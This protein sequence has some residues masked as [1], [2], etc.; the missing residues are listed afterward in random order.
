MPDLNLSWIVLHPD[1]YLAERE[2]LQI[3]YPHLKLDERKLD[4]GRLVYWGEIMVRPPGGTRRH[5][6]CLAYP[7]GF[8]FELP[9]IT[10][11]EAIPPFDEHGAT[12][13]GKPKFF[14]RRHQMPEGNLCLFQRETRLREAIGEVTG[15]AA[16]RRAEH[17]FLG[18]Y[19]GH[20]PPDSAESELEPHFRYAGDVL[21]SRCFYQDTITGRGRLWMVPDLSRRHDRIGEDGFPLIVTSLSTISS[22]GVENVI[23]A[24]DDISKVYPWIAANAFSPLSAAVTAGESA[25][26]EEGYW[27]A[28]NGEPDPFRDG[29]GFLKALSGVTQDGDGWD[30]VLH[31][32]K[33]DLSLKTR[34]YLA[35]RY[36]GRDGEP[37]WLV[38]VM[39]RSRMTDM[40]ANFV[41]SIGTASGSPTSVVDVS[42]TDDQKRKEFEQ[43]PVFCIR[44]HGLRPRDLRLRNTGVTSLELENKTVAFIGL[45]ALGAT[46]AELL[47]KAGIGSLRLCDSDRLVPGNVVRHVGSVQDFGASKVR[48]V[49]S[50][51]FSINPYVEI[52]MLRH[53]SATTSMSDLTDFLAASDLTIV[54][55][56]DEAVES[57]INQIAVLNRNVVLYGRALRRADVGR[58]FLVRPRMDACK[59][60]LGLYHRDSLAGAAT[61][62]D[63]ISVD[64]RPSDVLL[65]ECG[66]PVIPASAVDLAFIAALIARV[67]LDF[68]QG[69]ASAHNHFV[70]TRP[71][72]ADIDS[73]LAQPL[74]T[75]SA[76]L[77]PNPECPTCEEPEVRH[78]R[79]SKD[80]HDTITHFAEKTPNAE[81]GGILIGYV[82]SDGTA[83]VLQVTEPGPKSTRSARLFVRD[84]DFTQA[85]LD[86]A[87]VQFGEKG[88]YLG[89]WHSHLEIEPRP[90][91][92]DLDSMVGIARAQNYLTRCPIMI[93]VGVDSS[94]ARAEVLKAWSVPLGGTVYPIGT[95]VEF[96]G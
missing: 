96:V 77:P 94:A 70:W 82:D 21:L 23:D 86:E 19:T 65:H 91:S 54:T 14:D 11:L 32:L 26:L 24:R 58:V 66:R 27:W 92:L 36:P 68:L 35:L 42:K 17:W 34:H 59:T 20:W 47:A 39:P 81:T 37:E 79:F 90:S 67:A 85:K 9:I 6:I 7:D 18:H 22:A 95:S 2:Q 73:R 87:A 52:S 69:A 75:Y 55:T 63:W 8:P 57:T 53:G 50:R 45:G 33:T 25:P 1:R 38:L 29:A 84:T 62:A 10:P 28:L 31:A 30:D 46:V 51:L 64:E 40:S 93:I 78:V 48:V 15:I 71:P 43:S 60:C 88:A 61:P 4:G 83:N 74:T 12:A 44:A 5:N 72:S 16:L 56:A 89:E 3:H 13:P 49:A 76:S 41:A 80:A